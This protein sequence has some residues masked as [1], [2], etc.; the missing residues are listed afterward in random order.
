M[1]Q[2]SLLMVCFFSS[3]LFK[4]KKKKYK[5][6]IATLIVVTLLAYG[7]QVCLKILKKFQMGNIFICTSAHLSRCCLCFAN[8]LHRLDWKKCSSVAVWRP[9]CLHSFES[10]LYLHCPAG[11]GI[12]IEV[13]LSSW[14]WCPPQPR[15]RETILNSQIKKLFSTSLDQGTTTKTCSVDSGT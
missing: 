1:L 8:R 13:D 3:Q 15:N 10:V 2:H 7:W 12:E 11:G 9:H 5:N 4:K 14:S 6:A